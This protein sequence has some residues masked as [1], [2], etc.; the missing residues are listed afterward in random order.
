MPHGSGR[1]PGMR[2]AGVILAA[3]ASRRL[4]QAKQLVR[5]G[6]EAM[7]E[8][9]VRVA[10]E[11]GLEPVG[12]VL[13]AA[14]EEILAGAHLGDAVVLEN[15]EWAE[16]MAST[17]RCGVKWADGLGCDGVLVMVCDQPELT[18]VHLRALAEEFGGWG[19]AVA[20]EYGGGVGIP[21]VLPRAMFPAV[22]DLRGDQG[23]R[24][25]LR[26]AVRVAFLGGT[27]DVDTPEDLAGLQGAGR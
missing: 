19:E 6:G 15:P 13:G 3:G 25:L 22:M 20:S 26:S 23:A 18:A 9:T 27:R 8:R 2:L 24:G 11:A 16:G 10:A 1:I 5:V 21:A 7:L 17:L 4:G 12:V 14:M